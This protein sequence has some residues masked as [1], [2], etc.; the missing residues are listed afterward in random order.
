M[1]RE[2][3][4]ERICRLWVGTHRTELQMSAGQSPD[5]LKDLYSLHAM[6]ETVSLRRLNVPFLWTYNGPA[7]D[8]VMSVSY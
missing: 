6:I 2:S 5:I 8:G 3:T 4:T 7:R 1:E